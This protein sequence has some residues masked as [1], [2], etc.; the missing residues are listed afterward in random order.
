MTPREDFEHTVCVAGAGLLSEGAV[1]TI[2]RAADT[3]CALSLTG[4]ADDLDGLACDVE[5]EGRGLMAA[6]RASLTAEAYRLAARKARQRAEAAAPGLPDPGA[7]SEAPGPQDR[8][9]GRTGAS[10]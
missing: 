2:T 6:L 1:S 7:A 10:P 4:F 3:R 5:A 9:Q 8:V